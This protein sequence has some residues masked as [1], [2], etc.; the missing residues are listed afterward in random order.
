MVP[1]L[2]MERGMWQGMQGPL[3]SENSFWM[4]SSKDRDFSP[5]TSAN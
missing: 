4:T 1:G 3:G 2:K 5:A